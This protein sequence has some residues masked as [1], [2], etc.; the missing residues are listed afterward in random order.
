MAN[1][2]RGEV[3]LVC[4]GR[5]LTLCLT[6]GALAEIEAALPKGAPETAADLLAVLAAL[7]RGGGERAAARDVERLKV[8]PA[9]A[10]RAI[11]EAFA[12]AAGGAA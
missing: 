5:R 7:L 3:E 6:L 10:A 1:R 8:E 11:A 9:A 2:A 12:A 4:D